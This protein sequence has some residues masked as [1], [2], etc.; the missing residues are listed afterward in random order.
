MTD[1]VLCVH[2]ARLELIAA[3]PD[4]LRAELDAPERLAEMLGAVVPPGWPP[5]LYDS[6]AM[7]FFLARLTEG[8]AG[9]AGWYAWYGIRRA[10][11]E[12]PATLVA[13]G[14]YMG[15]PSEDGTVEIGY[16][17]V[18]EL[19]GRG[20][21]TEMMGALVARALEVPGVRRVAAEA[22]EENIASITVLERCGFS[23]VGLGRDP[24]HLRF[25]RVSVGRAMDP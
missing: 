11:A 19:R 21:A 25:E 22:H 7:K 14:G 12:A 24:G 16:S 13:A 18:P 6:D 5:G 9:T 15:P 20:Y 8:G 3:T 23:R 17:V 2:T 1:S 4:H 10:A